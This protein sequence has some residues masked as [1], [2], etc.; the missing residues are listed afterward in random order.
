[1]TLGGNDA[2]TAKRF[3]LLVNSQPFGAQGC[4]FFLARLGVQTLISLNFLNGFLDVATQH[5]V[6]A[7]ACHVGGNGDHAGASRLGHDVG[8]ACVLLGIEHLVW[9]L[10]FGE[11]LRNEF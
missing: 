2:Q 1:M 8:L 11:H 5:N 3:N 10:G 4:D 7:T 6:G 9:Q